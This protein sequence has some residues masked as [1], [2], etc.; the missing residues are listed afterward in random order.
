MSSLPTPFITVQQYLEAD[1]EAEF[2]SEYVDGQMYAM[3]GASWEHGRIILNVAKELDDQLV[4]TGCEVRASEQ[5]VRAKAGGPYYYPDIVIVCGEPQFEDEEFNT[6]LNAKLIIEVLSP[7]T[8]SYD[9]GS[10]FDKYRQMQSLAEYLLISQKR[11]HIEHHV[12]RSDGSW[13]LSETSDLNDVLE[14]SSIGVRLKVA[15]IYRRVR[16]E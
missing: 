5:R 11:V 1:R 12:L 4:D 6:L 7:S 13:H 2:R 8:E 10:K 14:L 3:S 16:F 9:R 15:D